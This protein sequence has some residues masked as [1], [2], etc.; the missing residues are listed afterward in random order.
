MSD[1][2]DM[3]KVH[4]DETAEC[5]YSAEEFSGLDYDDKLETKENLQ[6]VI[7]E[8]VKE[9]ITKCQASYK[10]YYDKKHEDIPLKVGD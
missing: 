4:L 1:D 5:K 10:K 7:E 6:A 9:N 3:D 2:L 8:K